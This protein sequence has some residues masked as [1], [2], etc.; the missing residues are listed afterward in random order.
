MCEYDVTYYTACVLRTSCTAT[1]QHYKYSWVPKMPNSLTC[2][3][4]SFRRSWYSFCHHIRHRS[5]VQTAKEHHTARITQHASHSTN[6][7]NEGV[8]HR[9]DLVL[10]TFHNLTLT[11]SCAVNLLAH[12]LADHHGVA[13]VWH[14]RRHKLAGANLQQSRVNNQV[15]HIARL[16]GG[17]R[18]CKGIIRK[19]VGK[20]ATRRS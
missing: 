7:H 2:Q 4:T 6:L 13:T 8:H 9:S 18:S 14:L 11:V 10:R 19:P 1:T 17:V 3:H 5:T 16:Q 20:G 12:D 15:G